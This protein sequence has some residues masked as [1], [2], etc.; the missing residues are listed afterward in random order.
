MVGKGLPQER[1]QRGFTLVTSLSIHGYLL[2]PSVAQLLGLGSSGEKV[3]V[4]MECQVV[5]SDLTTVSV[6]RRAE[7]LSA[8]RRY[9]LRLDSSDVSQ[10]GTEGCL[11]AGLA[12][13]LPTR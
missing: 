11:A 8:P 10:A 7:C 2:D 12:W 3:P 4:S 6:G 9:Q 1:R 5:M 13:H